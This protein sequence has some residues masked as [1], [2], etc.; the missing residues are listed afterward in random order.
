MLK[1]SMKLFK[2]VWPFVSKADYLKV[3]REL[4]DINCYVQD[5]QYFTKLG[6]ETAQ[7]Q[8]RGYKFVQWSGFVD[9]DSLR[10]SFKSALIVAEEFD[11]SFEDKVKHFMRALQCNSFCSLKVDKGKAAIKKSQ[12]QASMRPKYDAKIVN[13]LEKVTSVSP[14]T[15]K[16]KER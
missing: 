5:C 10:C 4:Q 6:V 14:Y 1:F 8:L 12:T 13:M 11:G 9:S 3:S 15:G 7:K 16:L 2:K